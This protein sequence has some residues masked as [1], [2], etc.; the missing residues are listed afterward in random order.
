MDQDMGMILGHLE[1]AGLVKETLVIFFADNGPAFL[2][3]LEDDAL[4]C[5][6]MSASHYPPA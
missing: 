1:K 2:I 3:Q 4:R 5:R 6:S